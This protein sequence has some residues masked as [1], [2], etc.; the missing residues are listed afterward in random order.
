MADCGVQTGREF[1]LKKTRVHS[2]RQA[3]Y[4][5][6]VCSAAALHQTSSEAVKG[7]A[8][9]TPPASFT[10]ECCQCLA[11]T[12]FGDIVDLLWCGHLLCKDCVRTAAVNSTTNFVRCPAAPEGGAQC[13]SYVQES[14]LKSVLSVQE[15]A[16]RKEVAQRQSSQ[17][18]QSSVIFP[19]VQLEKKMYDSDE[20][21]SD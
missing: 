13:Q 17:S 12:P 6:T 7:A 5:M 20:F 21:D 16:H 2:Q 8:L 18:S 11:E 3:L 4:V 14:A 19:N 15:W 10:V 1:F 9:E